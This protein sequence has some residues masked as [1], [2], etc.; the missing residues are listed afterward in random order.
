MDSPPSS[1]SG[2]SNQESTATVDEEIASYFQQ[3]SNGNERPNERTLLRNPIVSL[4]NRCFLKCAYCYVSSPSFTKSQFRTLAYE[5]V[6]S[7]IDSL[8]KVGGNDVFSIQY[9]GGEPTVHRQLPELI[10]YSRSK[11]LLVRISTNGVAACLRS[12][13]YIAAIKDEGVEWRVSLDSIHESV[14]DYSRG[15][16]TFRSIMRNLE[17]LHYVGANV[18][19]KPVLTRENI[20]GLEDYLEFAFSHGFKVTYGTLLPVGDAIRNGIKREL[21]EFHV[22]QYLVEVFSRKPHLIQT[23]ELSPLGWTLKTIFLRGAKALPRF[24]LYLHDDGNVYPMDGMI[25]PE[26]C[27]GKADDFDLVKL[28]KLQLE[29]GLSSERCRKCFVNG[30]CYTGDFHE[31]RSRDPSMKADFY[32][33]EDRRDIYMLLMKGA[34]EFQNIAR[35]MLSSHYTH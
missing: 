1:N 23:I 28:A 26:F 2:Y 30:F 18:S 19:L 13:Q 10:K 35:I 31:L 7:F 34:T 5:Y 9:F 16:G 6:V 17:H 29:H 8:L 12:E 4:T 20:S 21:N 3:F 32:A 33:C 25:G 14:N 24:T 27:L 11:N 15:A 22:A